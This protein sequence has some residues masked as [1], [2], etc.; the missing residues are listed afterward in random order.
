MW[1]VIMKG[2]DRY[3]RPVSRLIAEGTP[4]EKM[5]EIVRL[6]T[7]ADIN[8]SGLLDFK[9]VIEYISTPFVDEC[10][11]INLRHLEYEAIKEIENLCI[12]EMK[13]VDKGE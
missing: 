7:T 11:L 13:I 9:Y 5:G 4:V 1:R 10:L 3:R 8:P 12:T 6:L 2:L